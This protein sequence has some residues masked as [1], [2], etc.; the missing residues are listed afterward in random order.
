MSETKLPP[1]IQEFNQIT[2]VT[3][4]ELYI[5]FPMRKDL[6]LDEI[7]GK[8]GLSGAEAA[9]PSG[10]K[11]NDVFL[12]TLQWLG[13]E[14]YVHG[15]ANPFAPS[16]TKGLILTSKALTSMNVVPPSLSGEAAGEPLGPQI[17]T[18]ASDTT[19][20]SGNTFITQVMGRF[21]GASSGSS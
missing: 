2:T 20:V 9:L 4:A 21:F 7:A 14:G 8:L 10:R 13:D 16:P 6:S 18:A 3:F 17:L 12:N 11:F 15:L 5:A 1:N 19:S